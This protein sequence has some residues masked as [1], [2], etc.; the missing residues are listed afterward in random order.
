MVLWIQ[1]DGGTEKATRTYAEEEH[2]PGAW[3][4][5]N[6]FSSVYFNSFRFLLCLFKTKVCMGVL[7]ID[8][9][10]KLFVFLISNVTLYKN[11]SMDFLWKSIDW[12]LHECNIG[13]M[14]LI[15]SLIFFVSLKNRFV[16]LEWDSN[17]FFKWHSN[18][19]SH[20]L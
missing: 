5:K 14:W 17:V 18:L 7:M 16:K 11:Q 8:K 3:K 6:F 15:F 10:R 1:R 20:F 9:L 4:S 12:F 13:L 2:P 19:P